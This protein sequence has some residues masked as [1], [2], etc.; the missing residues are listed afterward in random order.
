MSRVIDAST[1]IGEC[2]PIAPR[3]TRQVRTERRASLGIADDELLA[4]LLADPPDRGHSVRMMFMVGTLYEAG[5]RPHVILPR[6]SDRLTRAVR[7]HKAARLPGRLFVTPEPIWAWLP[8]CDVA[9]LVRETERVTA[10]ERVLIKC[11]HAMG[12]PVV[13]PR[14]ESV[15]GLY[16]DE[17]AACLSPTN[18]AASL[19][20]SLVRVIDSAELRE[21]I[22][23]P[24]ADAAWASGARVPELS[25]AGA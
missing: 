16:P 2:P 7:F 10:A 4:C 8:A 12:V 13:G 1:S 11:A 5:L 21:R 9:V 24:I 3:N 22:R 14:D 23:D 19:A 20:R 18:H 15:A 17:A 25:G 6:G